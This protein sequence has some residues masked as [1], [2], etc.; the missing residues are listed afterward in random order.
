MIFVTVG[1]SKIPFDRLL[2][3]MEGVNQPMVV[4][5][6]PSPVRPAGARCVPFMSFDELTAEIDRADVIV[7]HAGVGSIMVAL[8]HGK[9]PFVVP[10]LRR[11]G[12]AVDDHQLPFAH[13]LAETGLITLVENPAELSLAVSRAG[14][15]GAEMHGDGRLLRELSHFIRA[16]VEA[17]RSAAS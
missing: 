4:Q 10:R 5:T 13:R 9:R 3:A 12:E 7:T 1:S 6:G 15:N 2:S 16:H 17:D 8:M 11:F 14:S